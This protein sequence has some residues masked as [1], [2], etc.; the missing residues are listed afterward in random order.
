LKANEFIGKDLSG[1]EI[2]KSN[3]EISHAKIKP[4]ISS[5]NCRPDRLILGAENQDNQVSVTVHQLA[6]QRDDSESGKEQLEE[7]SKERSTGSDYLYSSRGRIVHTSQYSARHYSRS[8]VICL[9]ASSSMVKVG[10]KGEG[11]KQ[12]VGKAIMPKPL[13]EKAAIVVNMDAAYQAVDGWLVV[14]RLISAYRANPKAII[15]GLKPVW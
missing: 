8:P 11:W 4:E 7:D 6:V 3:R 13:E 1:L 2:E 5:L 12:H 10:D 14:G 9:M 15:D